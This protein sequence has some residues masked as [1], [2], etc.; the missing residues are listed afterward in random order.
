M[1]VLFT[2]KTEEVQEAAKQWEFAKLLRGICLFLLFALGIE[3]VFN[4]IY[5]R[6][7]FLFSFSIIIKDMCL[8]N[9]AL[10]RWTDWS[11]F[12]EILG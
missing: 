7:L 4:E 5:I 9:L 1:N 10:K 2:K 3:F 12:V 8:F 11:R 6:E